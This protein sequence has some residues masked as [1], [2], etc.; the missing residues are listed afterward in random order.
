MINGNCMFSDFFTSGPK[1]H[2]S[3]LYRKVTDILQKKSFFC[4]FPMNKIHPVCTCKVSLQKN[5]NFGKYG[6]FQSTKSIAK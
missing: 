1:L 2:N 4:T 5:K 3:W 6:I